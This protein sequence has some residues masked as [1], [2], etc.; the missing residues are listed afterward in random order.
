MTAKKASPIKK[1]ISSKKSSKSS[2][3]LKKRLLI[4]AIKLFVIG[5]ATLAI[6][7]LLVYLGLFGSIP[8]EKE[9]TK[10]KHH[11]AS[12]VYSAD[13]KLMG[14][15]FVEQRLS[16]ENND[17]SKHVKNALVATEDS[18]FFEHNGLDLISLGRVIFRTILLGD[19]SQGGG[20]T[21]SQQLAKNLFPRKELGIFTL[22]V[23]KIKEIFVADRMEDNYSKAE[24]LTLYLNTVPFGENIY[25]IEV[26]AQ[27]FFGKKSRDLNPAEAA[28]LVGMLAANT[29]FNPRINPDRSKNRRNIVLGRM[30]KQGFLT[31]AEVEKWKKSSVQLNYRRI[32]LNS[33]ISPYFRERIRVQVTQILEDKYGDQYDLYTDGL[34]ITTTIDSRLQDYAEQAMRQHMSGLQQEFDDHWK[35]REPWEKNR[36][37][38][39]DALRQSRRYKG[40]KQSGL[41]DKAALKKM[42]DKV[43][44]SIFTYGGEKMVSMSPIDS[45]KH[46]LRLLNAGFV[47]ISPRNGRIMAWVGG[48]DHKTFQYDHV[49]SKRMVGSTFKPIVYAAAL[50]EGMSPCEFISNEQKVYNDYQDW[51]PGNSNG[52]HDGYYSV[53]GGLVNSVNTIS[54]EVIMRT[55]VANVIDLAEDMGIKGDIPKVPSIA[56][57]TAELS[58]L[59]MVG[60]YCTFANYGQPIEPYGLMKIEDSKGNVLFEQK[61]SVK[62]EAIYAEDVAYYMVEM[63][64]GVVERGTATSL[65]SVYGVTAQVAGKTGTTQDNS[66]GWF[67][68]YTPTLVAGAWVGNDQPSIHFRST[69]LGSGGYMA[70]PIFA[71]FMKKAEDS[72]R[73]PS[74]TH[75]TFKMMPD[76][77]VAAFNCLDYSDEQPDVTFMERVSDFFDGPDTTKS[78]SSG[79]PNSKDDTDSRPSQKSILDKMKDL[80]KRKN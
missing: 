38:Y 3:S 18:R 71:R 55:G 16:I 31:T 25:G 62:E 67:I 78:K 28:T 50:K 68:G 77:L 65:R 69:A 73:F 39:L 12:E 23:G 2:D 57:G 5:L 75:S 8:S 29:A 47:A 17:I 64:R 70:L 44:M 41:D 60:A 13:G 9:L 1:N 76:D 32:D 7:V 37:V 27:R 33:G 51:S 66:D 40:L 54:A 56:L 80:F 24:I 34:K 21:I 6:F 72:G 45:V 30:G 46:S 20:S 59:D 35:G 49:T 63:M 48:I 53:K 26:A 10:I 15:Y 36:Q 43:S 11:N 58:L 61:E 74:Y 79:I 22:P 19:H 42:A 14:R 52:K 4:W